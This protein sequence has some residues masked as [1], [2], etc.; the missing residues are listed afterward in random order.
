MS[1][2]DGAMSPF[3]RNE[4]IRKFNGAIG[5]PGFN[6]SIRDS[7]LGDAVDKE[8][9]DGDDDGNQQIQDDNDRKL[10]NKSVNQPKTRN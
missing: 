3:T 8:K 6:Q 2:L 10:N 5:S 4:E 7:I 9:R 1:E